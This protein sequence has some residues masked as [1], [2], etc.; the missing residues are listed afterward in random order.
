M[1]ITGSIKKMNKNLT[2]NVAQDASCFEVAPKLA[3]CRECRWTQSQRRK[4]LP[5]IFCRFYAFR[6]L[7]YTKG[8]LMAVAGFCDPRKDA[9]AEDLRAWTR[10]RKADTEGEQVKDQKLDSTAAMSPVK[11]PMEAPLARRLLAS[12][13]GNFDRMM[14]E[15]R[16]ALELHVGS[17]AEPESAGPDGEGAQVQAVGWKRVVQGVRE[18]CDVCDSTLFNLH[19]AC[20]RCGFVVCIDC[21]R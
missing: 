13:R 7:R 6:R 12:L 20:A 17:G 16:E 8:G 19:W 11:R 21:Y 1:D 4:Q 2:S 5:N 3:K 14:R 9:K 18:M 15:E 10:Q